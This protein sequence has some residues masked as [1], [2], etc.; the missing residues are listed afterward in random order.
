MSNITKDFD[1]IAPPQRIA[2]I[3]GEEVDVSIFPARATLKLMDLID[4]PEKQADLEAGKN[5]EAL[6][7]V[8]A[9]ACQKSNPKITKDFLLD[10]DI[11]VLVEF[12]EYVMEPVKRKV[13]KQ[14]ET[15]GKNRV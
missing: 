12:A 5:I 10:L 9:T 3:G 2:K 14:T 13:R 4:T 11:T 15:A 8:V 6:V 1:V 7:E